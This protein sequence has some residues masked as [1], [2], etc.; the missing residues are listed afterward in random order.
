L[1]LAKEGEKRNILTN[2]IAPVAMS[3]MTAETLPKEV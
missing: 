3:R 2:T 1:T